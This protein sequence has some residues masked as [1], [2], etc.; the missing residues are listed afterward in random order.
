MIYPGSA[1]FILKNVNIS[2]KEYSITALVGKSG[3]GKTTLVD[4]ILGIHNPVE[5]EVTISKFPPMEA[6]NKWPGAVAYVPQDIKIINGTIKDN[7]II[8]YSSDEIEET[9]ISEAIDKARLTEFVSSLPKGIETHIGDSG[10][11]LSGGQKQRLGIA[12]AL[13]TKPKLLVLD[14]ATNSMDKETEVEF[15]KL[16]IILSLKSV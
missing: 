12:R 2:L 9:Y 3:A 8:G 6:I 7:I 11:F 15:F 4:I 16:L 14:E 5:G 13:L 1:K 10:S